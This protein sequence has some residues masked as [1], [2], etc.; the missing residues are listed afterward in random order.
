[1]CTVSFLPNALGFYLAMNRDEELDRLIALAPA[2]VRVDGRRAVLPREPTG[3][4]WICANDAG[5]CLALINW[6]RV[7]REP[8][9][10]VVSR[11]EVVRALVARTS[12]D[13]IAEGVGKLPLRQ[14][15]PFR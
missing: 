14:L 13:E 10:D 9:N 5:V 12:A 11:G 4:S 2:I 15:R 1:M 8:R 7:E 3:G 6:H